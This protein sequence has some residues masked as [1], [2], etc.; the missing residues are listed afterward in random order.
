[1]VAIVIMVS[2][3]VAFYMLVLSADLGGED[4]FRELNV[5]TE[6]VSNALV[7]SGSP[8]NWNENNVVVLGVTDG[9]RRIVLSKVQE[10]SGMDY[11]ATRQVLGVNKDYR[12]VF[13]DK[14]GGAVGLSDLGLAYSPNEENII[15]VTRLLFYEEEV[16]R[17]VVTVW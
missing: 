13:E 2:G 8:V 9:K 12:I 4:Q 6:I 1:M 15:T 3:L 5:N 14:N 11:Q 10:I 16:I 7:S 17:M